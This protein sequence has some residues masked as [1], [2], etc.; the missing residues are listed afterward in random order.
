[1]KDKFERDGGAIPFDLEPLPE[2]G[3]KK[4]QQ[5][6]KKKTKAA[7]PLEGQAVRG[8]KPPIWLVENGKRRHI[9][10]MEKFYDLGFADNAWVH[11]TATE[12]EQIPEGKP[13][14]D[15]KERPEQ[16][17]PKG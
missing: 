11:L 12:L 17:A 8:S 16:T 1:M 15:V 10:S 2:P 7:H 13:L 9:P 14:P 4:K 3:P 6:P 5:K